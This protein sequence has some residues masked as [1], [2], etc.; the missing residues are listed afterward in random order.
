VVPIPG[1]KRRKYL[2]E[3]VASVG[4]ELSG[5][6][7]A[8]IDAIADPDAVAGDRYPEEYMRLVGQ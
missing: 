6:E 3:N 8:A 2:A 5:E 4:I 1:T 7:L